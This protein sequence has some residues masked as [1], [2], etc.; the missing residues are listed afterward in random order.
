VS[1]L[2]K[3]YFINKQVIKENIYEGISN[4]SCLMVLHLL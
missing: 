3:Y 1:I 4:I 2:Y